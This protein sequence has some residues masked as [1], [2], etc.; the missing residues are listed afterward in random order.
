MKKIAQ[1]LGMLL[2]TLV[3]IGAALVSANATGTPTTPP[4]E[5]C[6]KTG[7]SHQS[8]NTTVPCEEPPKHPCKEKP[9]PKWCDHDDDGKDDDGGHHDDDD[10][11]DDGDRDDDDDG[12]DNDDDDG[13]GSSESDEP[14]S[15]DPPT[16]LPATGV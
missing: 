2:G 3:L 10:G 1:L 7:G 4:P 5:E 15:V 6:P 9:K 8:V 14:E 16:G 11:D 12:D 13:D